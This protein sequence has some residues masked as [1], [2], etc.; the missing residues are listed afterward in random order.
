MGVD[1][2]PWFRPAPWNSY[3]VIV[4]PAGMPRSGY[5]RTKIEPLSF[6]VALPFPPSNRFSGF[7]NP[8]PPKGAVFSFTS[9]ALL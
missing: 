9:S 2:E 6:E 4:A 3:P 1:P 5:P 8:S 7:K